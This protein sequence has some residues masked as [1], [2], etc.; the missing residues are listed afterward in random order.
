MIREQ[1]LDWCSPERLEV[2]SASGTGPRTAE[3]QSVHPGQSGS[4]G[5]AADVSKQPSQRSSGSLTVS[6]DLSVSIDVSRTQEEFMDLTQDS[7]GVVSAGGNPEMPAAPGSSSVRQSA[8]GTR[9][10]V[11][12]PSISAPPEHPHIKRRKIVNSKHSPSTC[13]PH[14]LMATTFLLKGLQN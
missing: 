6:M 11:N 10:S 2:P 7:S 4:S 8:S 14:V 5:N 1:V 13:I 12:E 9:Q 3:H